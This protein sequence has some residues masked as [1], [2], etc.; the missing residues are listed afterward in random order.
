MVIQRGEVWWANLP[1]PTASGPGFRRPVLVVQADDFNQSRIKTIVIVAISTNLKLAK[2]SGNVS[3]TVKQS[4]L[5]KESVVNVSQC[6][7]LDKQLF[8]EYVGTL[9]DSKMEQVD[10]GLRLVLSL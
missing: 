8:D 4:G 5:P 2:A 1:E 6:L 10:K 9:S 3:I 7:T